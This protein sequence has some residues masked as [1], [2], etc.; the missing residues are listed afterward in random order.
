[1]Q[2]LVLTIDNLENTKKFLHFIEQ[3]KFI[4]NIEIAEPLKTSK[5]RK[6]GDLFSENKNKIALSKFD[7]IEEMMTSFGIWENRKITKESLR[8]KAWRVC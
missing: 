6:G 1:M 3:F 8:E 2:R 5:K 4:E 7:S